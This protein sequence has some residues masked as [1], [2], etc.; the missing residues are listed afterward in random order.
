[1][2]LFFC[3]VTLYLAEKYP[4]AEIISIS[5]SNSQ[6]E[7]IMNI[8]QEKGFKNINIFTGD[9][10]SRKFD[11]PPQYLCK[12]DRM[13]SIEMFEHMKNYGKLF[14]KIS[15]WLKPGGKVINVEY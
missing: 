12:L 1:M 3:S 15:R 14:E 2:N 9:I 11:L 5:N 10:A 8:A 7:F 13:I 4:N 6:R